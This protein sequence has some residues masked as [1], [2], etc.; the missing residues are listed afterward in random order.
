V[1]FPISVLPN[2]IQ[3]VA[4]A[5]PITYALEALRGTLIEGMDPARVEKSLLA[6]LIFAVVL[7]PGAIWCAHVVFDKARQK[8]SLGQY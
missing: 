6:L 7:V 1:I 2:W 8:G 5:L 4:R 3:A